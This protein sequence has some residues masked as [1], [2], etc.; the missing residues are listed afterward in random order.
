MVAQVPNSESTSDVHAWGE[1]QRLVADVSEIAR[2]S[3]DAPA[4]Y[5][6][7]IDCAAQALAAAGGAVWLLGH[8]AEVVLCNSSNYPESLLEEGRPRGRHAQFLENVLRRGEPAIVAPT[9]R[10]A[11][12]AD[13]EN[14]TEL[15][16]LACPIVVDGQR[17]GVLEILQRPH[18]SPATQQGYLRFLSGLCEVAGDFHRNV[19][20]RELRSR[21]A[22]WKELHQF[23][24]AIH[25]DFDLARMGTTVANEVRHI[26]DVDRACVLELA[27]GRART[28]AVSGVD[29]IQARSNLLARLERLVE[30]VTATGEPLWYVAGTGERPPEIEGPLREYLDLAHSRSLAILPLTRVAGSRAAKSRKKTVAALVVERMDGR[31]WDKLQRE[32]LGRVAGLCQSALSEAITLRKSP[33]S[34]LGRWLHQ[35]RGEAETRTTLRKLVI[36]GILIVGIVA[37]GLLPADLQIEAS[38]E[39]QPKLQR[40]VFATTDGEVDA[41]YVRHGDTCRS[42]EVL[43]TLRDSQL[44]LDLRRIKGELQTTQTRLAASRAAMLALDRSEP[45]AIARFNQLTAEEQELKEALASQ[46]RQ[47]EILD[48]ERKKLEVRSPI[49]GRVLTWDVDELLKSRP[50]RRGQALLSIADVSGPWHLKLF[51]PEEH[52]GHVMAAQQTVGPRLNVTYILQSDPGESYAG[53]I[54]EVALSATFDERGGDSVL[55]TAEIDAHHAAKLRPGAHVRAK[56]DCGQR[57]LAYVWLHDLY[58]AF[59]R[60]VMF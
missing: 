1:L 5:G 8:S 3:T 48:E 12:H 17:H 57:A 10:S 52:I 2:T 22:E 33:L 20:L 59:Q 34:R 35:L 40:H 26:V 53:S 7:L 42:D 49:T 55:V 39:L 4:F 29:T 37:V 14:P 43:L 21:E 58:A 44:E 25:E 24:L 46:E 36:A 6:K 15:L 45:D 41:L 28:L 27:G 56:I 51:V 18:A 38:G 11:T 47:L 32:R 60:W 23:A 19:E 54:D 9:A 31:A 13:H 50:V 30:A 16:L